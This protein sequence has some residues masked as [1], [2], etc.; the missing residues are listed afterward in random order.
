MGIE[1]YRPSKSLQP[2]IRYYWILNTSED[3]DTLTFPIGCPQLIFHRDIQ[4]GVRCLHLSSQRASVTH[5][6]LV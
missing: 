6:L 3:L 2:F 4:C 5:T 1:F